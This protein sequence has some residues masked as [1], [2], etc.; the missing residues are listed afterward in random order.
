MSREWSCDSSENIALWERAL[1]N[2]MNSKR[3]Q[4]FLRELEAELLAM[5]ARGEGRLIRGYLVA[6]G[7]TKDDEKTPV[8]ACT[9]GVM[10][11]KRL[12]PEA[13]KQWINEP[14]DN[15][16]D[17]P[18]ASDLDI[19]E[20][21]KSE[22]GVINDNGLFCDIKEETEEKRFDRMLDWVQKHISKNGERVSR[23]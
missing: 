23:Y 13:L 16:S 15:F 22:I 4:R 12:S 17:G 21:L 19:A 14:L 9:L 3:G 1:E 6:N 18:D 20:S 8:G 2:A 10:A 5:K 7:Q 11:R